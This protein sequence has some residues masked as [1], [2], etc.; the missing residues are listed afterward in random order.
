M[1]NPCSNH[2]NGLTSPKYIEM[3]GDYGIH[4]V[5]DEDTPGNF[6]FETKWSP[7]VEMF[8]FISAILGIPATFWYEE[9]GSGEYGFT[10]VR[11]TGS[12][13]IFNLA[14]TILDRHEL[15]ELDDEYLT[16]DDL[17]DILEKAVKSWQEDGNPTLLPEVIYTHCKPQ[18]QY[19]PRDGDDQALR[20]W[21]QYMYNI[22]K[23]C[24]WSADAKHWSDP[25]S[26]KFTA[27]ETQL[28]HMM[29]CTLPDG[30]REKLV[31][32]TLDIVNKEHGDDHG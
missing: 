5:A 10:E 6:S 17:D 2:I 8:Q 12:A 29:F 9:L 4:L 28:L 3:I 32:F 11:P 27:D 31:T 23:S 7:N 22:G 18:F 25:E 1:A 20:D 19:I 30:C 26:D 21:C 16:Y 14:E 13:H 24:D 15:D